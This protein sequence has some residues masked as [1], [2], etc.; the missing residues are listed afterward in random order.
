M[1]GEQKK[2]EPTRLST[3]VSQGRTMRSTRPANNGVGLQQNVARGQ[4]RFFHSLQH[5]YH[6]HRADIAIVS[7]IDPDE[8]VDY[9]PLFRF[10]IVALANGRHS[11]GGHSLTAHPA[12]SQ[13]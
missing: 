10:E 12:F 11:C 8:T 1:F 4:I 5:G 6:G 2:E 7:E 9:H 13:S 3:G